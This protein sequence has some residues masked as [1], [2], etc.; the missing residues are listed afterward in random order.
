MSSA[1]FAMFHLVTLDEVRG[2][3]PHHFLPRPITQPLS[4]LCMFL[5][6]PFEP[7]ICPRWKQN[8]RSMHKSRIPM[9]HPWSSCHHYQ[10]VSS[11][12]RFTAHFAERNWNRDL[13]PK[14][15]VLATLQ[16]QL[17]L[18]LA[19]CALQSQHNLLCGLCFLVENWFCLTTIT[20]LLSVITTL[21]LSE[22]RSLI[23]PVNSNRFRHVGRWLYLSGLVLGDLVL[24]VLAAILA[25]AVSASG[26]WDVD[27]RRKKKCQP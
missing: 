9:Q 23:Q 17:C 24:G 14:L 21:S 2:V 16:C 19:R 3:Q 6:K 25:F 11:V 7:S 15:E 20:R 22:Q 5:A 8:C 12:V 13:I 26:L 18:C 27:L 1:D 4:V 10:I